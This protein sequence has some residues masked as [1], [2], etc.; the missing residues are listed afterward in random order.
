MV[1]R[2]MAGKMWAMAAGRRESTSIDALSPLNNVNLRGALIS[3]LFMQ[4]EISML[5]NNQIAASTRCTDIN[6][7]V[8]V[9]NSSKLK[10]NQDDYWTLQSFELMDRGTKDLAV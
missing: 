2:E 9:G 7:C 8:Q 6:Q 4:L 1:A 5:D 3:D 10:L